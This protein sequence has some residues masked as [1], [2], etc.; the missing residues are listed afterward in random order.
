MLLTLSPGNPGGPM[1]PTSPYYKRKVQTLLNVI[2]NYWRY[3]LYM[4]I[5]I[6]KSEY[7]K[8]L[9]PITANFWNYPIFMHL[10]EKGKSM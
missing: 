6:Y 10:P 7:T 4:N 3:F 5:N 8:N 9:P 1:P 2:S